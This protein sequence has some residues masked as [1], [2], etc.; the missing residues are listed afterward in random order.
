MAKL[1]LQDI[2]SGY[3][4]QSTYNENNQ[5]VEDA[6]E[7]TL[8]RDGTS[9]NQMEA[10]LDMNSNDILNAQNVRTSNLYVN[11]QLVSASAVEVAGQQVYTATAT[12]GQ[13]L[14]TGVNTYTQ[15]I[16]A[17]SVYINGV[18]Q[19]NSAYSETSTTSITFTEGLQDGDYVVIISHP[20]QTVNVANA[21]A[22]PYTP[23]G[24]GAVATNVQEKL[25]EFVSVTDFGAVGD[26]VTMIL[27]PFKQH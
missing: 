15:G 20:D 25:R 23:A 6:V 19:D 18:Y 11:G 24:T 12:A 22:V 1:T 8:S 27:L 21:S 14:F 7:N 17:L 4:S 5:L 26:G 13:T 2:T 10:D 3:Q 9:P 16:A